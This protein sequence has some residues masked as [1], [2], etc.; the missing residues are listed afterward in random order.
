[1]PSSSNSSSS[2]R[3][4]ITVSDGSRRRLE[5]SKRAGATSTIDAICLITLSRSFLLSSCF[6]SFCLRLLRS[7]AL[8]RLRLSIACRRELNDESDGK[9]IS[10]GPDIAVCSRRTAISCLSA[11]SETRSYGVNPRLVRASGEAPRVRR[12]ET[13]GAVDIRAARCSGVQP[14]I[15]WLQHDPGR[16]MAS[17][18]CDLC[19]LGVQ[20]QG[21]T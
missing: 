8:V 11:M 9:G 20:T 17:T 14:A 1:M 16:N 10:D 3:S 6:S 21:P 5:G 7:T 12:K 4:T 18:H 19:L 15:A 2:S 13:R